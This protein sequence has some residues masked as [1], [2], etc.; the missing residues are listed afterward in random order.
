MIAHGF[1]KAH[2]K[3]ISVSRL[4]LGKKERLLQI[5][6]TDAF[7]AI[8]SRAIFSMYISP[9]FEF[10]VLICPLISYSS[11]PFRSQTHQTCKLQKGNRVSVDP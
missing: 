7:D 8:L 10:L 5:M 3:N 4:A 1:R 11:H 2:G 9:Y 6:S